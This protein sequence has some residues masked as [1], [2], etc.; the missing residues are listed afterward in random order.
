[1]AF[2]Y[3]NVDVISWLT[4]ISVTTLARCCWVHT[5]KEIRYRKKHSNCL[6]DTGF[7][8][9]L[10][11]VIYYVSRSQWPR[12]LRRRSAAA[13]LLGS[14]VRVP[15]GAW[16][17]VCCVYMLCCPVQVEVSETGWSLVQRSPAIYLTLCVI[18]KPQRRPRS[19][20]G[21]RATGWMDEYVMQYNNFSFHIYR[22]CGRVCS[23]E[24]SW[25]TRGFVKG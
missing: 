21:C 12:G 17:F 10:H 6:L 7:I 22:F 11:T 23:L 8:Q 15:L 3:L 2:L 1:M 25:T 16:M 19:D 20:L 18:K 13:L 24:E 4:A 14:P 5:T 9:I